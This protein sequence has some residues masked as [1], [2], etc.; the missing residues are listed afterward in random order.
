M[1][2]R[3]SGTGL[4]G[5]SALTTHRSRQLFDLTDKTA[6]VA[7]G[8][9]YLGT[10]ICKALAEQGANVVIADLAE[11][12]AIALA[13]E[14]AGEYPNASVTWANLDA[15]D[16]T[17]IKKAVSTTADAFGG[18]DISINCTFHSMGKTLEDITAEEFDQANRVNITGS[19][20]LA[21]ES[22]ALMPNGG[23]IIM[24]SSMFGQLAPDPSVYKPPMLPNPIEYGVGK[25]GIIQMVNY[26][27]VHWGPKGIR[28]NA[29]A[30]GPFPNSSLLRKEPEF[31]QRLADKTPLGRVGQPEEITAAV[32][33]LAA[34]EASYITGQTIAVNG[35]WNVW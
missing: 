23:S 28:V 8:A 20:L 9:G 22:A 18:L 25:A 12:R 11:D 31:V 33:F 1:L 7:G 35:G 6:L 27:A 29:I 30:P 10:P 13:E 16:E 24:F 21:R 19:F 34:D 17:S 15:G 14:T 4:T 2:W 5:T 32:I 3:R 26:L